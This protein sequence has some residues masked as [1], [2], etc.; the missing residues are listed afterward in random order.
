MKAET[1]ELLAVLDSLDLVLTDV[2]FGL[3]AET[4]RPNQQ[5]QFGQL[6]EAAGLLFRLHAEL[7]LVAIDKTKTAKSKAQ[8]PTRR[9]SRTTNR[10]S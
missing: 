5:E 3:R 8:P 6:L 4:L 10:K 2:I 9:R 1:K 7:D